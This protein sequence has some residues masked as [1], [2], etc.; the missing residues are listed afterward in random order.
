M[1]M[2]AS[3]ELRNDTAGVLRRVQAGDE[4]IVTVNGQPVARMDEK[5][6]EAMNAALASTY[7][8][9]GALLADVA[10]PDYYDTANFTDTVKTE[11]WGEIPV[12]VDNACRLTWACAGPPHGPD[13]HPNTEGYG[14]MARAFQAALSA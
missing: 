9:E 4:V 6:F 12:N 7:R 2:I 10:G 14:V 11:Q 13:I 3:R 5:A 8:N 1:T